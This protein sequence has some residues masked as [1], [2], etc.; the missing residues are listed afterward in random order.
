MG[1]RGQRHVPAAFAPGK[2]PV[3][4]LQKAGWAPGPVWI[5]AENLT[6]SGIRS[7]DLQP[8][9]SRYADYA[10]PAPLNRALDRKYTI[11]EECS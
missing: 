2:C 6:P 7:P 9:A 8:V 11:T 10:F 4:I 5:G 3:P 1:V